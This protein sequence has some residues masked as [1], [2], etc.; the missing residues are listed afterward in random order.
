MKQILIILLTVL[1]VNSFAKPDT[2]RYNFDHTIMTVTGD[3]NKDNLPDKVI[4]TQDT[5]SETAPY[6]VQIF[7]KKNPGAI[8]W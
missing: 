4:V 3:L 5:L 2:T 7:F 1:Q 6:Q 8:N